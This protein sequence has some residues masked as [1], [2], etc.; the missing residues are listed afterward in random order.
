MYYIVWRG[1]RK[2]KYGSRELCGLASDVTYSHSFH[3]Y[4]TLGKHPLP[5]GD[6]AGELLCC[7]QGIQQLLCSNKQL[8]IALPATPVNTA[9]RQQGSEARFTLSDWGFIRVCDQEWH[10]SR[11]CL[12]GAEYLHRDP[13]S[14]R[15]RWKGRPLHKVEYLSCRRPTVDLIIRLTIS[16]PPVTPSMSHYVAFTTNIMCRV[17]LTIIFA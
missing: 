4:A 7:Y 13:A 12:G 11:P 2:G 14:R 3:Q 5:L 10:R 15:R 6:V 16:P 17:I 8:S 9:T 1:W